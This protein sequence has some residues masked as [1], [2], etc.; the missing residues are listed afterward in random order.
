[1]R[2]IHEFSLQIKDKNHLEKQNVSEHNKERV[3]DIEEAF[4]SKVYSLSMT[5]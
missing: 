5:K 2:Q 4:T 3:S 1:M